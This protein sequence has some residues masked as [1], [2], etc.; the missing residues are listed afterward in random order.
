YPLRSFVSMNSGKRGLTVATKG[1]LEFEILKEQGGTVA[2][3]LLRCVGWL[4]RIGMKTRSDTAGPVMRTPGAQCPG[5]HEFEFSIIPHEGDWLEANVQTEVE[6]YLLPVV[7][8]YGAPVDTAQNEERPSFVK[9]YPEPVK[10]SAIKKAE[11][12]N[13]LIVRV[14]NCGSEKRSSTLEFGFP[15]IEAKTV[16]LAEEMNGG[17]IEVENGTMFHFD[18]PAKRIRTFLVRFDEGS[19]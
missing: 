8:E 10:I 9:V 2:L 13:G 6:N 1:L 4:S 14:W 11:D 18:I 16:N 5:L 17:R 7:A 15:I 3:T 19:L 12:D